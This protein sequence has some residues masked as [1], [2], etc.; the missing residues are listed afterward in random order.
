[1]SQRNAHH[2]QPDEWGVIADW[3]DSS[4]H[5]QTVPVTSVQTLREVIGRPPGDHESRAPI[6]TRPGRDLGLGSVEVCCED[7]RRRQ[8][9]GV[10]PGDFPLGYHRLT[11]Q[12]GRERSLIV[13]PGRCWLPDGWRSW[14]WAVQLYAAR[15]RESWGIGDLGDLRLLCE[16]SQRL[17]AGFLL[18]NPLHAAAPTYPQ[19]TSPYLPATRRFR[20]PLYLRIEDVPG[21]AIVG[22]SDLAQAGRALNANASIDRDAVWGLKREALERIS[23]AVGMSSEFFAWRESQGRSLQDFATWCALAERHGPD[24]RAWDSS[25]QHPT[26]DAVADFAETEADRVTFFGWLQWLFDRQLRNA[27]GGLA[28]I[29]DLPIGVDQGGADAWAWQEQLADG[30]R[31]GAPPDSFNSAGQEWGSP[32]LVPWRLR[33]NGYQAFVESVRATMAGGGGLRIDHVLGLFRQWWV[34]TGEPPADGAY[35]RF[36]SDDL[37]DIVALESARAK[38]IVVGEDLGTV[39]PG[40]REAMADRAI[41]SYRVLWFEDGSPDDW[42]DQ[43]MAAV[44]THDLPT[45]AGLWTGADLA[46]QQ[47]HLP[48]RTEQLERSRDLLLQRLRSAGLAS[49]STPEQAVLAAHRLLA[50]APSTLVCA[51]L[52]DAALA[53]QRPN[54]PGVSNRPNW[55]LPLPLTIEE[56]VESATA[57]SLVQALQAA[58]S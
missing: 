24:W 53:E 10:L 15:S 48:G 30:A 8:V 52:E 37:L 42:P 11:T 43:S 28:L 45:V 47:R 17:G 3:Q 20:S 56:I 35:V 9:D 29:Q 54:L 57:R 50:T 55:C 19:P 13:S 18:V 2:A 51:T 44:T 46:E 12:Q 39:G 16:W 4:Q 31:V 32:P 1:M 38:A 14:G 7:G 6:V 5:W 34:P 21:A 49:S 41:L 58:V 27:G 33:E 26:T 40:V 23:S 22:L 36:P 25:L